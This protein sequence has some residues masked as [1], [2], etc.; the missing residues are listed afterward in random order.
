MCSVRIPLAVVG[1]AEPQKLMHLAAKAQVIGVTQS[2]AER[3]YG[4]D[5]R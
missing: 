2:M 1:M 3:T 5:L 4:K